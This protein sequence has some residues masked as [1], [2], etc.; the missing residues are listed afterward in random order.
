MR[1]NLIFSIIGIVFSSMM[2]V[3]YF[4]KRRKNNVQSKFYVCLIIMAMLYAL[5]DIA[6][7]FTLRHVNVGNEFLRIIWNIR[8]SAFYVY[9]YVFGWYLSVLVKNEEYNNLSTFFK[10]TGNLLSLVLLVF[11]AALSIIGGKFPGFTLETLDFTGG[12]GFSLMIVVILSGAFIG[13]FYGVKY[14]KTRKYIL[15]AFNLIVIL[16]LTTFYFQIKFHYISFMPFM[17]MII[18]LILYYNIENPDIAL[19]KEV[20]VLK[21]KIDKSGNAKTDFLFNLSYDLINPMNAIISLSQSLKGLSIEDK[22][23]IYRDLKSI[24]YAGSALLDSIDNILDVSEMYGDENKVNEKVYSVYELLKRMETVAIA[25][26]GAKPVTFEMNIDSNVNSKLKGDITKIQKILLN[27]ITNACRFT[28]IGKVI[29]NLSCSN[30]KDIQ[31]LHF[32]ISDTGCGI[33]KEEIQFIFDGELESSGMGLALSKKYI[34]VMGASVRVESV[35]GAGAIF[36]LDIPQKMVDSKLI[37]EDMID[38]TKDDSIG[39]IDCSQYKALICDD[40]ILDIKVTRKLL[41]KYNFQITTISSTTECID[42]IKGEEVYDILFLDH[43]MPDIDGIQAMKILKSL[44]EYN[45]PKIVAL[46]ANA[47]T[48]AREYYLREGFDD[49]L[50]KPINMRELDKIIKRNFNK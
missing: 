35:Y 31:I 23:E 11:I 32:K 7:I 44:D 2:I 34:D 46:T 27:I 17:A 10:K 3:A 22:D 43:K 30:D 5:L 37:K 13:L 20:S 47:V 50:S 38:D 15:S 40:D 12:N 36:Y 25:R 1:Y 41:E 33:K 4:M 16:L 14:R 19:L 49:Y 28:D 24:K 8:N 6:S 26:I 48:G 18:L 39:F 42:R 9:V 45:I 21:N 29:L